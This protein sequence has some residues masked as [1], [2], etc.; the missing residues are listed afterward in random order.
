ML[1]AKISLQHSGSMKKES[2]IEN[3]QAVH[4]RDGIIVITVQRN[5]A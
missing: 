5:D 1:Q 3:L 2:T 4:S